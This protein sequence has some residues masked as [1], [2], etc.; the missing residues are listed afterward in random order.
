MTDNHLPPAGRLLKK[1]SH[2]L[3]RRK[4]Q[5]LVATFQFILTGSEGGE[6]TLCI[7]HGVC[8]FSEGR[9]ENPTV[10]VTA[11]VEVWLGIS[12]GEI[13][14]FRASRMGMKITGN[15]FMMLKFNS[16]FSGDPVADGVPDG[17]YAETENEAEIRKNVWRQPKRVLGIQA[18]PR[19]KNGATE[20]C[21]DLFASGLR[22]AG[23]IVDT[24]Y[25]S[26][27]NIKACTG[28]YGCWKVTEGKCS[29]KDD[30]ERIL[31]EIPSYDLMVIAAP[32]YVDSMPGTLKNFLDRTIPLGHPYIFNKKGRCRHPSR[33]PKMPNLALISVCGFYELE[34]FVPLV[35]QIEA[36]SHNMHMPLVA[37]LLRPHAMLLCEDIPIGP[38]EQ[39]K[40]SIVDAATEL[41]MT[42]GVSKRT[43]K[44]VSMPLTSRSRF[45]EATKS[46]WLVD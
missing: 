21:Y 7:D 5:N 12:S 16:Y 43:L 13:G 9:A 25:L 26:D 45:L 41:T 34:N 17:L 14:R 23:A 38:I 46:W 30:M 3:N 19:G 20:V 39:M 29:Q 35:K 18:S 27:Q 10:T 37:T 33:F 44:G 8:H 2:I 28:C 31:G 1:M 24:I 6:Y 42:G 22:K 40:Q 11:P 15:R 32:L 4:T 36:A